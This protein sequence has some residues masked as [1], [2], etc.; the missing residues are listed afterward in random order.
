MLSQTIFLFL[1]E[2]YVLFLH[3]HWFLP[4]AFSVKYNIR[5]FESADVMLWEIRNPVGFWWATESTVGKVQLAARHETGHIGRGWVAWLAC[6]HLV[7]GAVTG[8]GHAWTPGDQKADWVKRMC[9]QRHP[10]GRQP[11]CACFGLSMEHK[12]AWFVAIN[13]LQR[14]RSLCLFSPLL[15]Y[16]AFEM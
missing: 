16:V 1:Y 4:R 10:S 15:H 5:I 6:G 8:W 3:I 13:D 7:Q 9:E 14:K 2:N 11:M 12:K